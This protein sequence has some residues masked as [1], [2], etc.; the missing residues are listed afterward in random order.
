MRIVRR[1]FG[2]SLTLFQDR[3]DGLLQSRHGESVRFGFF[4]FVAAALQVQYLIGEDSKVLGPAPLV[5]NFEFS[6]AASRDCEPL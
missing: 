1:T 3:D 6:W 4:K 5:E 2:L